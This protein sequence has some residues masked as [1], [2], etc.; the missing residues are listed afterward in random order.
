MKKFLIPVVVL[1]C[2]SIIAL[3]LAACTN[4]PHYIIGTGNI[5]SKQYDYKD[6]T[7][8]EIGN[9]FQFEISQADFF[10]VTVSTHE[11]IVDYLNISQSGKTLYVRLKP[12]SYTSA[13]GKATIKMPILTKLDVSGASR[14]AAK[15]FKSTNNLELTASGASQLEMDLETGITDIDISGASKVTGNLKAQDTRMTISGAS[16]AELTGS[17]GQANIEVSGASH[18]DSP[19]MQLQNANVDVS[20]ASRAEINTSGTLS[21]NAS[22]ASNLDYSGKPTMGKINVTGASHINSK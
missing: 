4:F 7:N 21:V 3:P 22:G 17:T 2:L 13:D 16:R 9:A 12:G 6:F 10:S 20:G 19:N 11:N 15:G 18:F 5:I 1:L 14:G 8:V